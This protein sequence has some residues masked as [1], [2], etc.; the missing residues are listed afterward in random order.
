MDS[1]FW[2]IRTADENMD[3]ILSVAMAKNHAVNEDGNIKRLDQMPEGTKSLWDSYLE[4]YK[5]DGKIPSEFAQ[6]TDAM[7]QFKERV[8][9]TAEKFKG[10]MD[11]QNIIAINTLL[12]GKLIMHFRGWMP[13]I[14]HERFKSRNYNR[15]LDIIEEGK[16]RSAW[17]GG[18]FKE[19]LEGERKLLD[20][21]VSTAKRGIK[22]VQTLAFLKKF[23]VT[24]K[25]KARLENKNKWSKTQQ[26]EYERRRDAIILE[27]RHW[28]RKQQDPAVKDMDVED[29]LRMREKNV[30]STMAEV[31]AYL[32]LFAA[33]SL[34]GM[35]VG[36]DD[37]PLY[38]SSW[39]TR[40]LYLILN[41]ARLEMGFSMNPTELA[42]FM[43]SIVPLVGLF[44][45]II[46]IGTNGFD[47]SLELMGITKDNPYDYSPLFHYSSP[48][49]VPGINQISK[50]ADIYE[51]DKRN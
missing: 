27:F 30:A 37:E 49:L 51:T 11:S 26:N 2:F 7:R 21:L 50:M 5:K 13:G 14:L 47:E 3:A 24:K 6:G 18:S 15:I 40:K 36:D 43:G 42:V 38:K 35:K 20:I 9:D 31:R 1:M 8:K 4:G 23:T 17:H 29:Y 39:A 25:E 32:G 48:Y 46:K 34:A 22:A 16:F 41:R 10:R 44:E 33:L 28:Q 12:A 45:D 19:E